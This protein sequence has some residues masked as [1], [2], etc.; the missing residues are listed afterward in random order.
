MFLCFIFLLFCFHVPYRI[1]TPP[2]I[3]MPFYSFCFLNFFFS[4]HSH[5]LSLPSQCNVF[6]SFFLKEKWEKTK[7]E[8]FLIKF[9]AWVF[10]FV[11]ILSLVCRFITFLFLSCIYLSLYPSPFF[12]VFFVPKYLLRSFSTSLIFL[13]F[14][15]SF[16]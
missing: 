7:K 5:Q 1:D 9:F 2:L 14:R 15:L 10:I 3:K 6:G 12:I 4:H 16:L 8:N 11:S 13:D